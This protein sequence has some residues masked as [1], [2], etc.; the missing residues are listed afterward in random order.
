MY[1]NLPKI[2]YT[3]ALSKTKA[4]APKK[5]TW[6]GVEIKICLT[7]SMKWKAIPVNKSEMLNEYMKTQMFRCFQKD[8]FYIWVLKL[9][10]FVQTLKYLE[11]KSPGGNFGKMF[12]KHQQ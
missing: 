7:N 9:K 11:L 5:V 6:P 8:I 10:I 1:I 12:H 3:T 2:T 4:I